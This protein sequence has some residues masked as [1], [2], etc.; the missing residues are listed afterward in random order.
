MAKKKKPAANPARGF[1]T[2]SVPSKS[3]PEKIDDPSP[4][5]EA[6]SSTKALPT[7][8]A[9]LDGAASAVL[10][11]A[12]TEAHQTPEELEAQLERDELQLLV[13]K[14]KAKVQRD[15][16]RLD[17][18][19]RTERRV[20]RGQA[21]N[22]PLAPFLPDDLKHQMIDLVQREALETGHSAQSNT[23]SKAQSEEDTLV[24]CWTLFE[25]L[26]SLGISQERTKDAIA[27]LLK[28]P[29]SADS[30]SYIWGFQQCLDFLALKFEENQLPGYI[31]N[32][33]TVADISTENSSNQDTASDTAGSS[34]VTTPE[35]QQ[36][37]LIANLQRKGV[38]VLSDQASQSEDDLRVSD[39]ESDVEPEDLLSN[40]LAIK[41]RL[42]RYRPELVEKP[43]ASNKKWKKPLPTASGILTP[44]V[45]KLTT[46]L[47]NIESDIL[48]DQREADHTWNSR[49]A[50]IMRDLATPKTTLVPSILKAE[51][52]ID[53]AKASKPRSDFEPS[54]DPDSENENSDAEDM[55]GAMFSATVEDKA[56]EPSTAT[57][58]G[59]PS[60]W[61]RD[62]GK[63]PGMSPRRV[64][65]DACRARDSRASL[66]FRLVSP[67]AYSNRHS[68]M[69]TWSKDQERVPSDAVSFV[70]F[71]Q[72]KASKSPGDVSAMKFTMNTVACPDSQQ[73]ESFVATVALF[74]IF[75]P[76]SKEEKVYMKLPGAWRDLY[77]ELGEARKHQN[78]SAD[79]DRLK[80]IRSTFQEH[81]QQ[82][83]EDG[84]VLA[85]AFRGR[86]KD[87][88]LPGS[89]RNISPTK[90]V[91]SSLPSTDLINLW[92]RIRDTPNYQR[93]LLGRMSLPMFDFRDI[94]LTA[95]SK[96]QVIILCGETGCGKSTQLPA[97]ILEHELSQGKQCKIYCTEPRRISAI[98]LAQRVSEELGENTGDVGTHRSLVGYAIRLESKM[99]AQTRLIY[100]TVGVVLRMLESARGLTDIT[101][102]VLD[103]VH[104]RSIDT[105]F[106]LIVLRSLMIA[107][108]ELKIVLM[109]ATVDSGRFSKYLNDAPIINVPGRT[110]PVQQRFLEDAIELTNYVTTEATKRQDEEEFDATIENASSGVP[111][112]LSGYSK[113]TCETLSTYDEYRIDYELIVKL[114]ERVATDPD[115]VPFSKATLVF[116]PGIAEIR[117]LNDM[118]VGSPIFSQNCWVVPLHSSIASEEQQYAF[119]P[120]PHGVRKVVLATNIAETGIT[121]P[122]VTCV[123]DTGKHKEMRYDERR[124][125]SRLIQ[126][127]IS[128]ANA[129][130][131]RGRAGRVQEGICF[132]LFTKY[133]HDALMA[134]Q[135]TPEMLRLSLQDLVMR[136][137]I[138]G[139]GAIEETLSMALDPP[140]SKNIRRAIDALIEV[141]A[142]TATEEL[143]PLGN[144]LAKLPLDANLGKLCLLSSIFGCLDVGITIAAILSSKS[145]FVT[146]FGDK[147]RADTTRLA[148]SKGNSDLL[149]A[150]NAYVSWRNVSQS[151]NISVFVWCRKNYLSHANLTNI[152]DLK[153]Q[154]LSSLA[155]TGLIC[156]EKRGNQQRRGRTAFVH[157]PPANDVNTPNELITSSVIA[158]S[159]YPKLLVRD[160]KGWR[161]VANSQ[162]VSLHPTSVNKH[163]HTVKSLSYYSMMQTSGSKYYNALSTTAVQELPLIL[164]AGDAD[165]KLHAGVVTID[166]NRLRF[167][168][169]EWKLALALKTMRA[170]MEELVETRLKEPGKDIPVRLKRWV[171]LFEKICGRDGLSEKR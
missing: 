81:S 127:F 148:F 161:N 112:S 135:Q 132:H 117:E 41:E 85:A 100:A 45:R 133:R 146:P 64:L 14:H 21:Q 48:F 33:K 106:L 28:D 126:S 11:V 87:S 65:E 102:L 110:F 163:N 119:R 115:Y 88:P 92:H 60:V 145:P 51:I 162:T 144:Q 10:P 125:L 91:F 118:L 39:F 90:N 73:S 37:V 38:E 2:T 166:G 34:R 171:D 46:K 142:L 15:A 72:R 111:K 71:E 140:S 13:E 27:E 54:S 160:G 69:I 158:W 83:E 116:L 138:C 86:N 22:L 26:L 153:G 57:D 20:L 74:Y 1:A 94:A 167:K 52:Q 4:I 56:P 63:T 55:L 131:R 7:S 104:E 75:S 99:T 84:I 96:N 3:K 19:V 76:Y 70:S 17:S 6:D 108:P 105:D 121:I 101:H 47:Q 154:L 156:L 170:R 24:R 95:I 155:D 168:V 67:T 5:I 107:R 12:S 109:S 82:E 49:K 98:S 58:N 143:T 68:V 113:A 44:K 134:P 23:W 32:K 16:T 40:Y 93:M 53:Q 152:E 151:P 79:R 123:I 122:D 137:K 59:E 18:K 36:S 78:D 150:Y 80:L 61:L 129:K 43:V 147:Q 141:G 31:E 114:M 77:A 66:T 139:L 89:S 164:L 136:V 9:S 157:V 35:P 25:A 120:P 159:F 29:P 149:T 130:Q 103:E 42:Y 8:S 169:D 97:Y 50:I 128:R 62:F 30:S 124:Q 165:F